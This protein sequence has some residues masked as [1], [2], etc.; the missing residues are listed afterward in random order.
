MTDFSIRAANIVT[1]ENVELDIRDIILETNFYE[2]LDSCSIS[3]ELVIHDINNIIEKYNIFG[4]EK[5][6]FE[7]GNNSNELYSIEL[8]IYRVSARTMYQKKQCYI[9][10]CCTKEL[11]IN[12]SKRVS[13]RFKNLKSED[14]V[15]ILLTNYLNTEKKFLYDPSIYN[16]NFLPA[17]WRVFKAISWL[18]LRTVPKKYKDSGGYFFYETL[19]G[20]YN[21]RSVDELISAP[22]VLKKPFVYLQTGTKKSLLDDEN[23]RIVRF[24]L[25]EAFNVLSESRTGM[26]S[27]TQMNFNINDR[28]FYST[29]LSADD[30][31]ES[32]ATL[33]EQKPYISSGVLNLT[34]N[35]T[36]MV[37]KPF[38]GDTWSNGTDS[39]DT[40]VINNNIS[41]TIFRYNLFRLNRLEIEIKG[42]F[43][44]RVGTVLNIEIPT[45]ESTIE[46]TK[47]DKRLSGNYIIK[48]AKHSLKTK[49][50]YITYLSLVRDSYGG[51][52]IPDI[53]VKN[54]EGQYI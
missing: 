43:N 4:Q 54:K 45:P 47:S 32:S 2:S 42:N 28:K 7:V 33:N 41:K 27:H 34:D 13:K 29:H 21:Y 17:N 19:D 22:R 14:I 46:S 50:E 37:F 52:K 38:L 18:Q 10:H 31:F 26:Y 6:F 1:N 39:L 49:T 53:N 44:L 51:D 40:D 30:Y 3:A 25:P 23:F 11:L 15:E 8:Y 35:P 24:T 36:R 12:E 5:I 20:I 16:I 48:S 9:I